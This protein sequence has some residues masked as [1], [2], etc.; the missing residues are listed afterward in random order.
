MMGDIM[1]K[2]IITMCGTSALFE[3]SNWRDRSNG[4]EWK[5]SENL[6]KQLE[7]EAR[8]SKSIEYNHQKNQT[9]SNLKKALNRY[10]E[11]EEKGLDTL[12]AEIASLL[13]MEKDKE[14]GAITQEDK[15]MILYSDTIDGKLCAEVNKELIENYDKLNWKN[16]EIVKIEGLQPINAVKFVETGLKNLLSKIKALKESNSGHQIFINITGGYKGSIPVLSRAAIALKIPLVYFF[17]NCNEIIRMDISGEEI[18]FFTTNI[19][20]NQTAKSKLGRE[21]ES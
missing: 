18:T 11:N 1:S 4:R 21:W 7:T 20:S 2:L 16:T 10:Y 17:E 19:A 14:I 9:I 12:S 3:H 8:N 5:E 15:I 6:I 13:A